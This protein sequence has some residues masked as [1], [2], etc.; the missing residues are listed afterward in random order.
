MNGDIQQIAAALDRIADAIANLKQ[1]GVIRSRKLTSD[2]AEW[3]VVQIYKGTLAASR[4]QQGWDV[5]AGNEN[6]Q[7][8]VSSVP[9]SPANRWSYVNDPNG[10]DQLILVVLSDRFKVKE[11]YKIPSTDLRNKI[12]HDAQGLRL[13]WNDV[14]EFRIPREQIPNIDRLSVLFDT[15]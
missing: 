2:F 7:V 8:K 14:R 11:F 10:Y 1:L 9:D 6:V 3:L 12:R 5:Q 15:E 4:T 13:N